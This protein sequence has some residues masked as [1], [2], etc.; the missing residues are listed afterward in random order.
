MSDER[1]EEGVSL[2]PIVEADLSAIDAL[3]NEPEA[4]GEFQWYGWQDPQ[5]FRRRWAENGLL[6]DEQWVFAVVAGGE[7]AGFV[8]AGRA[9]V[10]PAAPYWTLGVQLLPKARG[11][12]IGTRAQ[13][14][15]VDYLFAHTPVMRLEADTEAGNLAEQRVLEKLG[16]TREGVQR[17]VTFRAG[18]WR[19][20]VRY[21][22]LRT[23]PRP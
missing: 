17:A 15:L 2:R 21:S 1:A 12:G 19:D 6:G 9:G 7:F 23:D 10:R 14:L 3:L 4:L 5:R 18:E 11:R 13:R 20:V 16:F 8:A 22:L